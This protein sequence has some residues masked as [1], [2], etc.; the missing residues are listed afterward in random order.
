MTIFRYAFLL[1]LGCV[2][3]TGCGS[4]SSSQPWENTKSPPAA[5]KSGPKS[6]DVANNAEILGPQ[7]AI[8]D[9]G[10]SAA[11]VGRGTTDPDAGMNP[12]AGMMMPGDASAA[13][14]ENDGTLDVGPL[15]WTVPKYWVRKA[16][17][18]MLLAEYAVP[19][20]DGDKQDARLTVSQFG[21]SVE[22][23][24]NR[25]KGQFKKLDKEKEEPIDVGGVKATLVD[26]SGTFADSR[27]PMAPAVTRPDYRMLAAVV[28]V[29]NQPG[30][31]FIKC[32]GPAKTM[33]GHVDEVKA[34]IRSMKVDK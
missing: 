4:D 25:W 30:L 2:F 14:P 29:P 31:T 8:N 5:V 3:C 18:M 26:L 6:S 10:G 24:I 28:E 7:D 17:G 22:E 11:H 12:H 13:A 19:K 33:A 32:Y 20:A 1:S 9:I 23:N 15:H 27:G 34:F 21:G 16:P